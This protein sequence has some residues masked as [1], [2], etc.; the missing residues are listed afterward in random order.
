MKITD[1]R[2]GREFAG[3]LVDTI[4]AQVIPSPLALMRYLGVS[5][6]DSQYAAHRHPL[7]YDRLVLQHDKGFWVVP[8]VP[9]FYE[10]VS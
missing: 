9:E 2:C 6:G 4:P 5:P 3:E 7:P 10:V 1:I 8:S